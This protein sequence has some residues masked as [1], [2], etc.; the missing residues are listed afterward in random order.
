MNNKNRF[1]LGALACLVAVVSW[2]TMF[3]VMGSALKV[4]NPFLFTAIRYTAAGIMFLVFLRMREG[5]SA[6]KLDGRAVTLWLLGSC[7]FAGFGFLVFLGQRMA[8]TSGA[9]SASA[10]MALMPMLSI[11]INWAFRKIRP[12]RW[13][14]AFVLLSFLGVLTVVTKGDYRSLVLLSDNV[15]ADILILLGALCWVIYTI[16]TAMFPKWSGVRYTA[17]TTMMG[18]PTILA[19]NVA[20]YLAGRNELVSLDALTSI[21]PHIAYMVIAAGFIGVLCW[22]VG[23]KII[24]PVNGVLFMDVV[25]ATTFAISAFSGYKFNPAELV[26]VT[27]TIAALIFNNL[28]QRTMLARAAAS[29][30]RSTALAVVPVPSLASTP[31]PAP[32]ALRRSA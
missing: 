10:M 17:L 2:G 7:G 11:I 19:V 27:M 9:L 16:G 20:L 13:S 4:M 21:L 25:P 26:G 14:P 32:G 3:P 8:G 6:F 28:Y 22:N 29:T 31:V 30:A 18:V 23:N 1:V 15:P 24:T 5:K 12:L